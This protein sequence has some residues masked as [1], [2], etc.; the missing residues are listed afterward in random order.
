MRP[1]KPAMLA[2]IDDWISGSA[3]LLIADYHGLSAEQMKDLR[4]QLRAVGA[5]MHVVKNRLFRRV[6][7]ARRWSSLSAALRGP[8]ALVSGGE[9]CAVA[10]ALKRFMAENGDR[11]VIKGGVLN[12]APVGPG[13]M[14]QLAALPAREVLLGMAV[15]TIAAPLS[16]LVGALRQKLG[17]LLYVLRAMQQK[18]SA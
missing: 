10:K 17:A 18:K 3:F 5:Q 6:A 14:E 15:G 4:A 7:E 16:R 12:D 9:I 2:A 8:T 1:E 13:E 11:P